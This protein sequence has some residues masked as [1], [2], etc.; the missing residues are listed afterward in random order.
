[1]AIHTKLLEIFA[2]R[3]DAASFQASA[4][5][6][7]AL[8]GADSPEWVRICQMGSSIDPDNRIYQPG[9]AT[10]SSFMPAAAA[11]AVA[12]VSAFGATIAQSTNAELTAAP[13]GV[14]LDLDL[15]F[16]IDDEPTASAISDVTGSTVSHLEQTVKMEAPDVD[17]MALDFDISGPAELDAS[18]GM[19]SLNLSVVDSHTGHTEPSPIVSNFEATGVMSVD[20][21]HAPES[22]KPDPSGMMEF[23]MGSLSLD[24]DPPASAA[25]GAMDS[26]TSISGDDPLETKLALAEEFISIGDDDG[27]RALIE[28][29]VAQATGEM[30]AKAQR[31]LA[32]LG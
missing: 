9:G 2:K 11:S 10:T 1:L 8:T 23:D 24:L 26:T 29:V 5:Q 14:D 22:A 13:S 6:A 17:H 30:R 25:S 3:R 31:V 16:S 20:A 7:L 12:A 27:A 32:T 4:Q 18:P 28:E 21:T 15:D 19:Q